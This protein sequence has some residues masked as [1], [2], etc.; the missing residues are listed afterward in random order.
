[1]TILKVAVILIAVL[2]ALAD[3]KIGVIVDNYNKKNFTAIYDQF[4]DNLK[5]IISQQTF[6]SQMASVRSSLGIM[7][8]YMSLDDG[9]LYFIC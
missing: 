7:Q 3:E 9:Q 5:K 6:Q 8:D 4:D 1:M 2:A